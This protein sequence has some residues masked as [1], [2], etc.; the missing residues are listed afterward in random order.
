M[1][2]ENYVSVSQRLISAREKMSPAEGWLFKSFPREVHVNQGYSIHVGQIFKD[3]VLLCQNIAVM[4]LPQPQ[5]LGYDVDRVDPKSRAYID[6]VNASIAMG[7]TVAMGRT[8]VLAGQPIT[9]DDQ[10]DA[11]LKAA[12]LANDMELVEFE[13]IGPNGDVTR[14]FY[15]PTISRLQ[16]FRK[17]YDIKSGWGIIVDIRECEPGKLYE[18]VSTIVHQKDAEDFR[19]LAQG[20]RF[21]T[22]LGSQTQPVWKEAETLATQSVGRALANLGFIAD[23]AE[24]ATADEIVSMC[25][26]RTEAKPN[27]KTSARSDKKA[28]VP[29]PSNSA[30]SIAARIPVIK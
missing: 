19:E 15:E 21:W 25:G 13:R 22:S 12:G 28:G 18:F 3:E 8:L 2:I 5:F 16:R 6:A 9:A 4:Q 17:Q 27:D 11:M 23:N 7:D 30:E 20:T 24:V 29:V 1:T 14:Q 26:I 10:V